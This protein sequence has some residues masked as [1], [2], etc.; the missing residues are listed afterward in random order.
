MESLVWRALSAGDCLTQQL[1]TTK[2]VFMNTTLHLEF[3]HPISYN[4]GRNEQQLVVFNLPPT[5]LVNA[6]TAFLREME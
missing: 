4:P 3:L 6:A 2:P 5:F 1:L